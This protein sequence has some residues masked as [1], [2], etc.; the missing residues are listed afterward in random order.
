MSIFLSIIVAIVQAVSQPA[1]PN[2]YHAVNIAEARQEPYLRAEGI[3]DMPDNYSYVPEEETKTDINRENIIKIIKET[4]PNEPLML[5]IAWC[6]SRLETKAK[7]QTSS[8]K[9]IF[10]II[11]GTWIHFKCEGN[12]LNAEDNIKCGKKILDGQGLSAWKSS[13][14]CWK[15]L[16][17]VDN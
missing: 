10:Q 13:F 1:M 3:I 4:F 15:K 14:S 12:L 8:A 9:G 7:N 5:K 2:D 17:T 11:D 16:S 6:E